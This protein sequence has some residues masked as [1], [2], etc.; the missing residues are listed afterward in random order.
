MILE[1]NAALPSVPPC[2]APWK[3]E[4]DAYVVGLRM[5]ADSKALRS[6][7]PSTIAGRSVKAPSYLMFV[8]YRSSNVGPYHEL[9]FIPGGFRFGDRRCGTIGRIYVS[10]YDSVVNGRANWGIPKDRADF[11][12]TYG[13]RKKDVEVRVRYAGVTIAEL[14]FESSSFGLPVTSRI[15]PKQ[16]RTL[17]HHW[18]GRTYFTTPEVSGVMSRARVASMWFDDDRFPDV[19]NGTVF[20]A[21]RLSRFRMTFPVATVLPG[22]L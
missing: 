5:P 6:Q 20:G 21:V 9:L 2:P 3:L 18:E 22:L 17:A 7:L 8:D 11:D 1:S 16:K 15:V 10:T 4:G 13:D 19:S 12:V 14:R